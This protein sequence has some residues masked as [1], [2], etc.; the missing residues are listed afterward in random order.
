MSSRHILLLASAGTGK[1]YR[2]THRLIDLL[3]SGADPT[4]MLA[5]TFTRKAA[6]EIQ[7]RLFLRLA[8]GALD[9]AALEEINA[10]LSGVTLSAGQCAGLLANIVRCL[11]RFG[12]HTLDAFFVHLGKLY[13]HDLGLP[14][15]WTIE[16]E[17]QRGELVEEA[18]A[19]LVATAPD[20]EMLELLRAMARGDQAHASV[21]RLLSDRVQGALDPFLESEPGAWE[22]VA[23][24]PAL[25]EGR[26]E[27]LR[28][29]LER[30]EVPLTKRGTP[31][32]HWE[33]SL[34]KIRRAV[35]AQDW[36]AFL[37]IPLVMR[38]VEGGE[39]FDRVP[40]GE[41][42]RATITELLIQARHALLARHNARTAAIADLMQR[43]QAVLAE[44]R[45]ER[46]CF[47]FGDLPRILAPGD[48]R[49]LA[50]ISRRELD[51]AYRLDARIDHLL[52]D[53]FQDTSPAQWRPLERLVE[54]ILSEQEGARSFFCVGDVKQAIY[55]WRSGESRLLAGLS[56]WYP[57]L[58]AEVLSR[59]F[60]SSEVVLDTVNRVFENLTAVTWDNDPPATFLDVLRSWQEQFPSHSAARS[61]PGAVVM[62]QV[63]VEE[64]EESEEDDSNSRSL[65]L[66]VRAAERVEALI[67]TAPGAT[68][69][70]L[71][72]TNK[73]IAPLI[74]LL[75]QRGIPASGEGGNPLTDSA[76]VLQML[77]LLHLADHPG[78]SA[79]YLNV[80]YS[81]LLAPLEEWADRSFEGAAD[82]AHFVRERLARE[83]LGEFTARFLPAVEATETFGEWDRRRY[84]QLVDLAHAEGM[85]PARID[86]FVRRVRQA[87]VENPS[88]A[89]V[90]VMT[91]HRSKGLE[92]DAVILP[93]LGGRLQYRDASLLS[94]RPDPRG[95]FTRCTAYANKEL[96]A[97]EPTLRE[98]YDA[99]EARYFEEALCVL[100]VAMTR[101]KR[102]LELLVGDKPRSPSFGTLLRGT[103]LGDK[104]PEPDAEGLI[105]RHEANADPWWSEAGTGTSPSRSPAPA[106]R[107]LPPEHPREQF[108][109]HPSEQEGPR[110]PG[111][112]DLLAPPA[113]AGGARHGTL[114]HRWL[115]EVEWIDSF[116]ATD[117]AL[118][119]MG[120]SIE[121]DPESRRESLAALR[122]YLEGPAVRSALAPPPSIPSPTL[123]RERRFSL[124]LEDEEGTPQLW[125]GAFDRVVLGENEAWIIDFKTDAPEGDEAIEERIAF[126]RPQLEAYRRVLCAMT[127]LDPAAVHIELLFLPLDLRREL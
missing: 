2:L 9:P 20:E 22:G 13:A 119:C 15:G 37:G 4:R 116:E 45:V 64:G 79:A 93:E 19:R 41:S 82:L 113:S 25:D 31:R 75:L 109:L 42:F 73:H 16:N 49:G 66:L 91:V 97:I 87:P 76:A 7:T 54:E 114:I 29:A 74:D 127:G 90:K 47:A 102:R 28:E 8:E 69:G 40:I 30:I 68:I 100:Y 52:L 110:R 80:E 122:R 26:L 35:A 89:R 48:A 126:Y 50:A 112:A 65:P 85:A 70:V 107:L 3:A 120:S 12:V 83:N 14:P 43:Y 51:L 38:V 11:D 103:L 17:L 39:A 24:P 18:L 58:E 95:L 44:L 77:C 92:F 63:A 105:W 115:E 98:L 67:R 123:W 32:K 117:D 6:G 124:Y 118:L 99:C 57:V 46:G 86:A 84:R 71:F 23:L 106:L 60:R 62:Y 1:T 96:R 121:P 36:E 34:A 101:A 111:A 33:N 78:D 72:R 108:P 27:E 21:H 10:E 125:T 81:P 53:E 88:A 56:T 59:N 5:S 55:G 61:L 104:A 94:E